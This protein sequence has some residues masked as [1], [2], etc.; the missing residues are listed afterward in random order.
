MTT[1]EFHC[2]LDCTK[3]KDKFAY[4][5]SDYVA[6]RSHHANS[7]WK[8]EYLEEMS[9]EATVQNLWFSLKSK[10]TDQRNLFVPKQST[11]GEPSCKDK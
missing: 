10:L 3:P 7:E 1:F 6:M 2:N 4:A 5:N 8:R 11:P 9:E